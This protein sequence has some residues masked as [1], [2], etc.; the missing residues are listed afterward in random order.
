MTESIDFVVQNPLLLF[1]F[2]FLAGGLMVPVVIPVFSCLVKFCAAFTIRA[3]LSLTGVVVKED[4]EQ[5]LSKVDEKFLAL[6]RQDV[7]RNL[8]RRIKANPKDDLLKEWCIE[9]FHRNYKDRSK[10]T[11]WINSKEV[12]EDVT[13]VDEWVNKGLKDGSIVRYQGKELIGPSEIK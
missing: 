10:G 6:D 8:A 5:A 11:L 2:I 13:I 3:F 12:R 4:L 9:S 7:Y 1:L